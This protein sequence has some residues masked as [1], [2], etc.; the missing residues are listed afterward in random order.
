MMTRMIGNFEELLK[1]ASTLPRKSL[2]VVNPTNAETFEA[3]RG[4]TKA[5]NVTS[6][7]VGDEAVIRSGLSSQGE[8]L[9]N[10]TIIHASNVQDALGVSIALVRQGKGD[11]LL[12]GSIDTST[13]MRE[14]LREDGGLR[15][16]RLMSDIV[17]LEYAAREENK[18]VMITDGGMNL[19]PDLKQK[20]ELIKNAVEVAH[21]LGNT[22]PKVAVLSAT[23]FVLPDLPSTVDAAALA[24]MNERGQ[25]K[26]CIVDGPLALD[27]ALSPEAAAEKGI[28]SPVAGKAEILVAANIESANSLAKSTTYFANLPLAHVIVGARVPILIPSRADKSRAK[29][30]SVALGLIVSEYQAQTSGA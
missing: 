22:T 5:L 20:V 1:C 8:E 29:L 13:M 4:C 26:G 16:G 6:V 28:A 2:V 19:A 18:F 14:V 9:R 23:E 11:V 17:I 24:K 3:V 25:I 27:N 10:I 21:A 30:L 15:L 7:L 12:K